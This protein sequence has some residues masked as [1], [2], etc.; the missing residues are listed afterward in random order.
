MLWIASRYRLGRHA[1]LGSNNHD[2]RV[3]HFT[4]GI[5]GTDPSAFNIL[6]SGTIQDPKTTIKDTTE[7]EWLDLVVI[8]PLDLQPCAAASWQPNFPN[9]KSCFIIVRA[10]GNG[11]YYES[12]NTGR[13]GDA[14]PFVNI[15][16][17]FSITWEDSGT[18]APASVASGQP[19]DQTV[20]LM[21]LTLPQ[22]H[23]LS[24]FNISAGVVV[25]FKHPPTFNFVS[26]NSTVM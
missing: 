24:H 26:A 12:L 11:R 15:T 16:P 10:V 20:S 19:A 4:A 7:L 25:D 22:S 2:Y 1:V 5:S 14:S 23:S 21:N 6:Q 18:T 8:P 3:I 13:S 17:P 9:T